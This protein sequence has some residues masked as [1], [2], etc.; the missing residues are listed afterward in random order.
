MVFF[1]LWAV[2]ES[3]PRLNFCYDKSLSGHRLICFVGCDPQNMI[4]AFKSSRKPSSW[5]P[6]RPQKK[7]PLRDDFSCGEFGTMLELTC[8]NFDYLARLNFIFCSSSSTSKSMYV[9]SMLFALFIC[10]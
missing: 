5:L 10:S 8:L 4:P 7:S 1:C 3:F 9:F 2:E 6:Y